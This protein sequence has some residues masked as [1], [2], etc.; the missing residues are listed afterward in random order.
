MQAEGDH[1]KKP[2]DYQPQIPREDYDL[3]LAVLD[4]VRPPG[5]VLSLPT[6]AAVC[7][8]RHNTIRHVERAALKKLRARLEND[9]GIHGCQA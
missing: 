9:W 3:E 4:V 8:V 5:A 6:I 7:G 2:G 1:M